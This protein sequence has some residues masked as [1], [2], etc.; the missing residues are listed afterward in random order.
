MDQ[1]LNLGGVEMLLVT[2]C[3]RKWDEF[4]SDG[5]FGSYADFTFLPVFKVTLKKLAYN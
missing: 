4:G 5:S 2:S 3:Y 1:N